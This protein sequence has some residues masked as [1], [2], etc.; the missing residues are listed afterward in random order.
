MPTYPTPSEYQ[1]AVQFPGTAFVDDELAEAEPRTNALGLPQPITGAFAAVFPVTTRSGTRYAAKCFLSDIPDQRA[2][3]AVVADALA[4]RDLDATVEFDYQ[5]D[6]IRVDGDVYPLLKMEWVEGTTLNRFVEDH[7]EDPE[8]LGRLADAW[9]DLIAALGEAGIAHGD[10]QH[11]NV[12]VQTGA[13]ASAN[14][15]AGDVRLRLV[16]YDT[17]YVPALDGR[18]SAEVGHRNY[19]HP[20]R[21]DTDFGPHLDRF[22]GIVVYTALRACMTHAHLWDEYD[23]G[24]NLLFRDADFYDPDASPLFEVLTK[25]EDLRPLA[26]ALR[27][28]CYVEPQDVPRLSAVRAGEAKTQ[29]SA[30][31]AGRARQR[32]EAASQTE[33]RKPMERA[34]LP[35]ALA[36]LL[37]AGTLAGLGWSGGALAVLGAA[38]A[39]GI[40]TVATHYRR[41]SVVRRRRRLRQEIDRFDRL[42]HNLQRQVRSL[43]RQRQ[44][45]LDTVEERREE[46]LREVQEEALYDHLKHHFVGEAREVDGIRHKHIVRLKAANIR[47]AYEATPER[48][49]E[50]RRLPSDVK[51]RLRMWRSA[52]IRQYEE[53]V[54][55]SLSPAEER[56]L[57]R[58]VQ[59]RVEDVD[60]QIT[61]AT[62]KI[63]VQKAERERIRNRTDEMPV[64]TPARYVRY[65]LRV[66]TIPSVNDRS[67]SASNRDGRDPENRTVKAKASRSSSSPSPSSVPAPVKD[68]GPWWNQKK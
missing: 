11:G 32:R 34:F 10:L 43:K 49:D 37:V 53:K 5:A 48:V 21:T 23:T 17:V 47:T 9:A 33:R 30:V 67:S 26:E 3:Y 16:D 7:L 8:T 61:R 44:E 2:R 35:A 19:Q 12:L 20:D 41:L 24:E 55:A 56:R 62:E 59:Q 27:H 58:Y 60:A 38:V 68:D 4:E 14:E 64:V 6:G 65:L 29:V 52:L 42:V 18:T 13:D 46:R 57:Q 45:I 28:A 40:G 22:P 63:A 54:P 31:Q 1:E 15:P 50:I 39:A 36:S 25:S 51:T 66:D